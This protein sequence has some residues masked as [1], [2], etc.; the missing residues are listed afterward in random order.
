MNARLAAVASVSLLLIPSLGNAAG[1]MRAGVNVPCLEKSVKSDTPSPDAWIALGTLDQV[2]GDLKEAMVKYK[3]AFAAGA[4][5]VANAPIDFTLVGD[6]IWIQNDLCKVPVPA[7]GAEATTPVS[8]KLKG[9]EAPKYPAALNSIGSEGNA[10]ATATVGPDGKVA[11]VNVKDTAAGPPTVVHSTQS[12]TPGEADGERLLSRVQFALVA[13]QALRDYTFPDGNAGKVFSWKVLF[14]PPK[15]LLS[16]TEG[17]MPNRTD[18][19]SSRP[20]TTGPLG[21]ASKPR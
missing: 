14:V 8:E 13:I 6:V 19:S 12:T 15:D 21:G 5:D 7:T 16:N 2:R 3:K 10:V 9:P 4:K 20:S 18:T 17:V 11:R 1:A